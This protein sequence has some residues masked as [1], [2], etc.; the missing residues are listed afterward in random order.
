MSLSL[1]HYD[2]PWLH[3]LQTSSHGPHTHPTELYQISSLGE[4]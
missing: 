2:L 3:S 1:S 4:R